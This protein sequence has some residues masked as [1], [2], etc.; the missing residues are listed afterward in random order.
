[1][2]HGNFQKNHLQQPWQEDKN[3]VQN[4]L[5]QKSYVAFIH[6]I[7]KHII[8]VRLIDQEFHINSGNDINGTGNLTIL[9]S[10]WGTLSLQ[11]LQYFISTV[12][13][14][15]LRSLFSAWSLCWPGISS[16]NL[17]SL[18]LLALLTLCVCAYCSFH[19][20]IFSAT[21]TTFHNLKEESIQCN[22][23]HHL[24]TF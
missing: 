5:L 14:H 1:M 16:T 3:T 6:Y 23:C 12:I 2:I 13:L 8:I 22:F 20:N 15:Q 10:Y 4:S 18:A 19:C 17:K 11:C 24:T 21:D 9:R 7:K